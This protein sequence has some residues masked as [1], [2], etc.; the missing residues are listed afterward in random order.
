[1]PR[2]DRG[3]AWRARAHEREGGVQARAVGIASLGEDGKK[4]QAINRYVE[5]Q[6]GERPV[7]EALAYELRLTP[8]SVLQERQQLRAG[9]GRYAALRGV[10][11]LGRTSLNR[12]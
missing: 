9:Y 4:I 2:A 3:R 5:Q 11:Y 1:V 10:S 8:Q 12:I 7:V 6:N